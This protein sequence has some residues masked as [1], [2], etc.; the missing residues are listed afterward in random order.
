MAKRRTLKVNLEE[1]PPYAEEF[2][3]KVD[4]WYPPPSFTGRLALFLIF[5][6]GIKAVGEELPYLLFLIER[7][8]KTGKVSEDLEEFFRKRGIPVSKEEVEE[9]LKRFSEKRKRG[10]R[11]PKGA[12]EERQEPEISEKRPEERTEEVEVRPVPVEGI[13]GIDDF[14]EE[15]EQ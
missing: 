9:F 10:Q 5:Y 8:Q 14:D 3:G 2:V 4:S 15:E 13:K 11:R 7:A 6:A 12:G 1:M